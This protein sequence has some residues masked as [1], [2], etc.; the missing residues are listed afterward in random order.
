MKNHLDD[1]LALLAKS[2]VNFTALNKEHVHSD[3]KWHLVSDL[4]NGLLELV[5][6]SLVFL[7]GRILLGQKFIDSF[8]LS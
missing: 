4:I 2:I 7:S 5:D 1:V 8:L 3:L 6:F